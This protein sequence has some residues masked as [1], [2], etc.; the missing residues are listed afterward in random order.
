MRSVVSRR[1]RTCLFPETAITRR[2]GTLAG[3]A[4][5]L[6][7]RINHAGWKPAL[8]G[9]PQNHF[10]TRFNMKPHAFLSIL[11]LIAVFLFTSL[12]SGCSVKKE[13]VTPV[14]GTVTYKGKPLEFGT[15]TFAPLNGSLSPRGTIQSDGSFT[16]GTYSDSDGC[17]LGEY[18]VTIQCVETQAPGYVEKQSSE[19]QP[20]K[21]LIPEKYR[22]NSG[23]TVTVKKGMEP[24]TFDLK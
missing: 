23:I 12:I 13:P 18:N 11:S 7:A 9:I 17:P 2:L 14:I 24:L 10:T 1:C 5:I 15:V 3:N 4:A 19:P 22:S 20:I 6:A 21:S 8:P 16:M